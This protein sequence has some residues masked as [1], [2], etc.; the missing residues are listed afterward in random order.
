MKKHKLIKLILFFKAVF[1]SMVSYSNDS[2][3]CNSVDFSDCISEF[4]LASEFERFKS[5]ELSELDVG[6]IQPD[7]VIFIF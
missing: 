1:G 4:L 3:R 7:K 2:F 6:K 5:C